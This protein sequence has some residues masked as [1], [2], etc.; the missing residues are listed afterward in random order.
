MKVRKRLSKVIA[1]ITAVL[2]AL[3]PLPFEEMGIYGNGVVM[4]AS[5]EET[6]GGESNGDE[7]NGDE[8]NGDE[9]NGGE[10]NGGET[11]GV[12]SNGEETNGGETNGGESNG[13]ETN[14]DET[15]GGETNGGETNDDE[16]N[17]D[18]SNGDETDEGEIW[19]SLASLDLPDNNEL[20][21]GYVNQT[22]YGNTSLYAYQ[23]SGYRSLSTAAEKEIYN[24]LKPEL[25][26][27]ANGQRESTEITVTPT[28]TWICTS[29]SFHRII[30][31]LLTDFPYDV[32]WFD[33]TTPMYVGYSTVA[34]VTSYIFQFP[35]AAAYAGSF[36]YTVNTT[37]TGA[38]SAAA[39]NAQSIVSNY[40][41]ASD[42]EKLDGYRAEICGLVEYNNAALAAGT[43]YGDPW[44]LIYVFD[45]DPST[46]VVCEGYSKAFQ[47]LCELTEF[48]N[49]SIESAIVSGDMVCNGSGGGHMWNIVS[50]DDV[51]Y[52]VDVTNC[53]AGTVGADDLLFLKG[54]S[55]VSANG[56]TAALYYNVVY[57]Y[58][59]DTK[60]TYSSTFLT[61]SDEDYDPN[62]NVLDPNAAVNLTDNNGTIK[63]YSSLESAVSY[64]N[65]KGNSQKEY[66]ITLNQDAE[67]SAL[68]LPAATKAASIKF[69]GDGALKL[70]MTSL[71]IPTNVTFDVPVMGTNTTALAISVAAGKTLTINGEGFRNIGTISGTATSVLNIKQFLTVGGIATFKE[72]N[73]ADGKAVSVEGN[74]TGVTHFNGAL[75]LKN[76]KYTATITNIGTAEIVLYDIDGANAKVTIS[77]IDENGSLNVKLVDSLFNEIAVASGRTILWA[78]STVDFTSKVT[79][80]N[81]T[82]T[83]QDLNAY[84]YGKEIKA[85]YGGAVT[86]YSLSGEN[87]QEIRKYPNLDL[88]FKGMT[89]ATKDYKVTLNENVSAE[90][91]SF[92]TK[93]K[94]VYLDGFDYGNSKKLTIANSTLTLPT[95]VTFSRIK[96]E[97][98]AESGLTITANKNVD[99]DFLY[100]S[101]LKA[102]NGASASYISFYG[103]EGY[104]VSFST[105]GFGTLIVQDGVVGFNTDAN[106]TTSVSAGTLKLIRGEFGAT[107]L[108][109][110]CSAVF[111]NIESVGS[112]NS[113][114]CYSD[115][116]NF[117]PITVNGKVNAENPIL[118]YAGGENKFKQDDIV[119]IS[120]TA[121]LSK[122]KIAE[123]S[124]PEDG[125]EYTLAREGSNVKVKGAVYELSDGGE[126]SVKYASWADVLAAMNSST[127]DYTIK[128]LADVT[129][130]NITFPAA[131]KAKSVTLAGGKKLTIA[132]TALT[133]PTDVT[134][135]DITLETTNASGLT[136]T[137]NKNLTVCGLTS[138][139]LKAVN[140]AANSV[141]EYPNGGDNVTYSILGFGTIALPSF[142]EFNTNGETATTVSA[143][144][145]VLGTDEVSVSIILG[146]CNAKF[147]N[148]KSGCSDFNSGIRYA[149]TA[150]LKPVTITGTVTAKNPIIISA[151]NNKFSNGSTVLIA[152]TAD[153]SKFKL[154]ENSLPDD[155]IEYILEREGSEV[156]VRG[157]V[158]QLSD[159]VSAPVKYST[160]AKVVA[161]M[162]SSTKDYTVELL[163]DVTEGNITFPAATK[164]KSVTVDGSGYT[165][166]IANSTLTLPT[167]VELS[168]KLETTNAS[169]LTITANKN[170]IPYIRST[171]LKTV[172]GSSNSVL[173][174]PS[175]G[176]DVPYSI[177]GFGTVVVTYTVS[178]NMNGD[179]ATTVSATNLVLGTDYSVGMIVGNCNAAFTNVTAKGASNISYTDA[180]NFK[181]VTI[182]GKVTAD[183]PIV[184][185]ADSGTFSNGDTVLISATA[186]LSK[187]TID[188][189]CL[190]EDEFDYALAREGSNVKVK[191]AAYELSSEGSEPVKFV[192]WSDVV[193][194]MNDKNK[195]YTVKLLTDVTEGNIT[196]PAATKAKSVTLT[197]GKKLTIANTALTLPTDVRF[198]NI[199][200]ETTNTKSGLTIT[201]SKNV[202]IWGL[203]SFTLKA[204]NGTSASYIS[205]HGSDGYN[206]SYNTS[207][208]GTLI[209]QSLVG[210]NI[211][212]NG[213]ISISAGTLK[214]MGGEK[215]SVGS[216][217]A[218]FTNIESVG[219]NN[220][221]ICY[222]DIS[223]F[224]PITVNGK[225]NAENPIL[226]YAGGENKFK[227]DDIVLISKTADLSKF[228]IA[229]NSLP[230]DGIEYT[231][232]REGSNVKVKGAVYELSS[233][234]SDPVKY[235][236]WAD[237][238]AAM[239]S[240]T[241]D[242]TIK[243]LADVTEENITFPAAAKAKSVTLTGEKTLTI[244]NTALALPTNVV[245]GDIK[246]E[247]TNTRSGL[248]VTASKNL[249]VYAL[250]STT[251]KTVNGGAQSVLTL[252][253]G[254]GYNVTYG[255]SGFGSVVIHEG[256]VGFNTESGTATTVK[257]TNLV[258]GGGNLGATLLVGNCNATFTNVTY[259]E[260]ESG[261]VYINYADTTNIKPIS[262]TGKVTADTPIVISAKNNKFSSGD[263]VLVSKTAELS[264]FKVAENSLPDD[265]IEYT[266]AREGS[267]VK[268]KGAV[269]ELSSDGST[270][271]K[272]A[273]WA[274]AVAAMN[275]K[276][277]D[278]TIKL[279]SDVTEGNITFPAATKAK[280]VTLTGGK[281]LTIA[282]S[283]LALPTDVT[284]GNITLE[285][286]NTRYGLTITA[287]KELTLTEFKSSTVKTINGN[288]RG[289]LNIKPTSESYTLGVGISNFGTVHVEG[290]VAL[291][292]TVKATKLV[293]ENYSSILVGKNAVTF[294]SIEAGIV[295]CIVYNTADFTPVTVNGS[296]TAGEPITFGININNTLEKFA[297]GDTV[298]IS[299]TADLSKF[300]LKNSCLPESTLGYTLASVG[301]N[302]KIM[303]IKFKLSYGTTEAYFA[304]WSDILNTIAANAKN[305]NKT[306]QYTVSLLTDADIGGALTMPRAGTFGS[307][308]VQGEGA[309]KTLTFTGTAVSVTGKTEFKDLILKSA[310]TVRET[311][312][313]VDFIFNAGRNELLLT[314]VTGKIKGVNS[315]GTLILAGMT[316][317]GN[318]TA[319]S[320]KIVDGTEPSEP[321]GAGGIQAMNSFVGKAPAATSVRIM[322]NLTVTDILDLNGSLTVK[323]ALSAAGIS[324]AAS[325]DDVALV[326]CKN[327][328]KPAVIGKKGFDGNSNKIKFALVDPS[329]GLTAQ[330]VEDTVIAAINGKYADNLVPCDDSL[331]TDEQSVGYY[332]VK[333]NGK[334][335]AKPKNAPQGFVVV[336]CNGKTAYYTSLDAAIKDI[337]ATGTS[338]DEYIVTLTPGMFSTAIPKLPLP[339]AGKYGK[340]IYQ[341]SAVGS[342]VIINVTSDITLTGELVLNQVIIN[343][344][345]KN[346][347]VL[348]ISVN[349]GKYTLTVNAGLSREGDEDHIANIS[350]TGK[351]ITNSDTIVTGRVNVGTFGF[352]NNTVTLEG[353]TASFTGSVS[354]DTEGTLEYDKAN[355][356]NVKFNNI[357]GN[358]PLTVKID[359][360]E[361]GDTIAAITGDYTKGA[362]KIDGSDLLVVRSGGYL[363]AFNASDVI[364]VKEL[365][366]F[367]ELISL[368]KAERVYDTLENAM[369][370]I[371]RLNNKNGM[372]QIDVTKANG[373]TYSRM[374]LPTAGK[375]NSIVFT[376][377][378]E[379]TISVTSDL[380]LT[381]NLSIVYGIEIKKVDSSG[382]VQPISVNVGNYKFSSDGKLSYDEA[383]AANRLNNVSG[384][385]TFVAVGKTNISGMVN[386]GT[387]VLS[388]NVSLIGV[389]SSFAGNVQTNGSSAA[390]TY[391]LSIAKNV[392]LGTIRDSEDNNNL[393]KLTVN[394]DGVAAGTQIATLT[395][396]YI[397]G[398]VVVGDGSELTAVRSG[399]KLL[400]FAKGTEVTVSDGTNTRTYDTYANA[401]ADI[402][403]LN[404]KNGNYSIVLPSG[405][406]TLASL[407]LPARGKYASIEIA[408]SGAAD[409]EVRSDVAL[410]G[411][412]VIGTNVTL[413]K[414]KTFSGDPVSPFNFTSVKNRDGS[415]VYTVKTN[416][417]NIVYGKLNGEAIQE[418][419]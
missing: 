238:V 395:G 369:T 283:A 178:F 405:T 132:N 5:A 60:A 167:D 63:N 373:K 299:K 212:A 125:I 383:N 375:Y 192:Y 195:D 243:L 217:S 76:P 287:S 360:V 214:L 102:I 146:N 156:K 171:T 304:Q 377:K 203:E 274:D 133:L 120:K 124:L 200:L 286:T 392:R 20:F 72:V 9:T 231:L 404:N 95:N 270:P 114:I 355:A 267:N 184:I 320:L 97:T 2:L 236:S 176:F 388:D 22:F 198:D 42:F 113:S 376:V 255:I 403:R 262:I 205:F 3:T 285:T 128:L 248:T 71:S 86:L 61:V 347:N 317:N 28:N 260:Y 258:L 410:T 81:K 155:G 309:A 148:V 242:Y 418:I 240:S 13:G 352:N 253:G 58:D 224:K 297:E 368:V 341:G 389:R 73:V 18:E 290:T 187:F 168:L 112:N 104:P 53:D 318:V 31:A 144:N 19:L 313:Y 265:S 361:A 281:T 140:G 294:T 193:A 17:D 1:G 101:T 143:T 246:L 245:F 37:K 50:I 306:A 300:N 213:T 190:P 399:T 55:N 221:S 391:P 251:L 396:D 62:G 92:P 228:K 12:E 348:P 91:L 416:G 366:Y 314:N 183:N 331:D 379:T 256:V 118:I 247:T 69:N 68:S 332:I 401:I 159:G 136:I 333:E 372:Y 307:L 164:A 291:A 170:L 324:S 169:G 381:G 310:K 397:A 78:G 201:A 330:I 409:I 351:F 261:N 59:A 84:L 43:P 32:Y 56:F 219:S 161:A 229:E 122:F 175:E 181:P 40:E 106:G 172:K 417:G 315:S 268:V 149:D 349:L 382:K 191:C 185:S 33:K 334:L 131:T 415:P 14:G 354:V 370:D 298:L 412:V 67:L 16:S 292:G 130:G 279:L 166:T 325:S 271:V 30:W 209:V 402:T 138:A 152:Q 57:T 380:T 207:G 414:V 36:D 109:G 208:F 284:F 356:K 359:G 83:S 7:S 257:A 272:Y 44:Q 41:T 305:G 250:S 387:F 308:T 339:N 364:T 11:N 8:T 23:G 406:Y 365:E 328:K 158:Y 165:L 115:I 293:L 25:T 357:S 135:E 269:F 197:G 26:K 350:G 121:D 186:D 215:L 21:E 343:K 75:W 137:A 15:N 157:A 34:G 336:T 64:I 111:T 346:G 394:I 96:L 277:K 150:N 374:P 54:M 145:L 342:P 27:L 398:S 93:A 153:L 385:G 48:S 117:K 142:V 46:D 363:K 151:V 189:N 244:S 384:K 65:S 77:N 85:E 202:D 337:N 141:L 49:D 312:T 51:S 390:L 162:N 303:G 220:S 110:S 276:D 88:A 316:V 160:W 105:S 235:A 108:V 103:G 99:I 47:Y 38:A 225:V 206:V 329:T 264:K 216:C 52:V 24:L 326:L 252:Y 154:Y 230:D 232:A 107:I 378:E 327:E 386:V 119:L 139:S 199:T 266:L 413:K 237:V 393:G 94:S 6:N 80:A 116:S 273:S 362:I 407:T 179:T 79:I 371:N 311:T 358:A 241:K 163:T 233:D 296:V 249:K 89:D 4:T 100:S 177:S 302:V 321:I 301:S 211:D 98:T 134:F 353:A 87:W 45:N 35:V 222:S 194:A 182:T 223:N 280:S 226:I 82:S 288:A 29:E 196:F 295:T 400:A 218:V 340:F 335:I 322:G 282:N 234:G 90:T 126:G 210:F 180:D 129:E 188:E 289:V 10:T 367:N 74:V 123:N 66:T 174:F 345:D 263:T 319:Y 204:I 408:A 39:A 419:S 254:E 173:T 259:S 127:K 227:Q 323:G 278:Y 147:T 411:N 275:D 338:S 239:N 70:N 344:V